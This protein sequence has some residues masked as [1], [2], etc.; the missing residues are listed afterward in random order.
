LLLSFVFIDTL[1]AKTMPKVCTLGLAFC[2]DCIS[3]QKI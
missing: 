3:Q 1:I 2:N